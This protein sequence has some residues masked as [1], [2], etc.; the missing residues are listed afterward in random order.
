MPPVPNY[1]AS[2]TIPEWLHEIQSYMKLL[3]YPFL[4]RQAGDRKLIPNIST[5]LLMKAARK[6]GINL[7]DSIGGEDRKLMHSLLSFPT[8]GEDL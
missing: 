8:L 3:Q 7:E 2:M 1:K 5:E 6:E 4:S